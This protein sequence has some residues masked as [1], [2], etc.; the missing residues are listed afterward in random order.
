[1]SFRVVALVLFV[2]VLAS[3]TT[4]HSKQALSS[5]TPEPPAPSA[6]FVSEEDS[7]L[8]LLSLFTVTEPDHYAVLLER[9]RRRH[10]CT[11]MRLAQLDFYTDSW[12]V[13]AFPI[14]RV[15]LLCEHSA[16]TPEPAPPGTARGAR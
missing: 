4:Y 15:T 14:A 7:G 8:M 2:L 5:A 11:R 9:A 3:C 6:T 10:R 1:M 16:E 12:L 13:V